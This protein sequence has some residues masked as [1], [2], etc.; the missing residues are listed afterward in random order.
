MRR[1]KIIALLVIGIVLIFSE[2]VFA[3]RINRYCEEPGIRLQALE[4]GIGIIPI[5]S[6]QSI[7]VRQIGSRSLKFNS[8]ELYDMN[9]E[10]SSDF[11]PV[12]KLE[13]TSGGRGYHVEIDAV[14]GKVLEFK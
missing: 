2:E 3:Y 11:R 6:A 8:I 10:K 7:A 9:V 1:E 5:A 13:C 12:Y 14:T 4:K